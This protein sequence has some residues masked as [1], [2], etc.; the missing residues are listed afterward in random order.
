MADGVDAIRAAATRLYDLQYSWPIWHARMQG[1][2]TPQLRSGLGATHHGGGDVSDPTGNL[3]TRWLDQMT[4]G[5]LLPGQILAAVIELSNLVTATNQRIDKE[6][7]NID[8]ERKVSRC[9]GEHD[10]L[11]TDLAVKAGK[12]G[13]CYMATWRKTRLSTG[14]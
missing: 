5:E 3:A 14:L 7:R 8:H 6:M 13:R 10:P 1:L 12:C 2:T 11:C 4:A 9:D